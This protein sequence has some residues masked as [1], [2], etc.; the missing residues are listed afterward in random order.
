[1]PILGISEKRRLP[2][3]GKIRTGKKI[4]T[5]DG[6]HMRPLETKHF[7]LNPLEQIVDNNG[8][9]IS[10][11]KNP[12]IERLIKF[13]GTDEPYEIPIILPIGERLPDGDFFVAPQELKWYAKDKNGKPTV[14]CRGNGH[15]AEYKGQATP[16]ITGLITSPQQYLEQTG[17]QLPAGRNRV[18]STETCPQFLSKKQCKATMTFTYMVNHPDFYFG[19]FATDTSSIT[20]M[21]ALN[22]SLEVAEAAYK[23]YLASRGISPGKMNGLAGCPL[24]LFRKEVPNKDGG[25]NYPLHVEVDIEALDAE[26]KAFVS[27]HSSSLRIG[28]TAKA[29]MIEEAREEDF[30]D[31]IIDPSNQIDIVDT[32][33][34]E[35]VGTKAQVVDYQ[36]TQER[37][38]IA[39][40]MDIENDQELLEKFQ[41]LATLM[42]KTNNAKVRALTAGMYPERA[43]LVEYLDNLIAK[44]TKKEDVKTDP[45][46]GLV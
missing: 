10:E 30:D 33:T 42:G 39:A 5:R 40:K 32:T 13:L 19:V 28:L 7:V 22:S 45:I 26:T 14:M 4:P 43:A 18:C 34:G 46:D 1:M 44:N 15:L 41:T 17:E 27:G 36:Q 12:N 20:A 21:I 23:N 9:I 11:K 8:K 35:I 37:K 31:S 2:R 25:Y 38:E 24:R 29:L 6:K 16:D 3:I